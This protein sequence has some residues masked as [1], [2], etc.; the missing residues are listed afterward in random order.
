M[1]RDPT[2]ARRPS[3]L[4]VPDQFTS[5]TLNVSGSRDS[6]DERSESEDEIDNV[7]WRPPSEKIASV[8]DTCPMFRT[9][10]FEWS[11]ILC[12][13]VYSGAFISGT[14]ALFYVAKFAFL[15]Q[16]PIPT[17]ML[18]CLGIL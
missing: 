4:P 14:F 15:I 9:L 6:S 13:R 17:P 10:L 12:C 5:S 1:P 18:F 3:I 11:E 8:A 2:G 16:L 7:P